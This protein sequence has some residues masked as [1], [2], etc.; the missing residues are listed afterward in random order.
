[1]QLVFIVAHKE[2][3]KDLE[4]ALVNNKHHFTK[5]DTTGGFLQKKNVTYLM[6]VEDKSV[7]DVLKIVKKTCK[8]HEEVVGQPVFTAGSPGE[9]LMPD[10]QTKIKVGGATVFTVKAEKF[11]KI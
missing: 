4:E 9:M 2:N 6:G 7:D 11:E 8:T 3:S 1:M 10:G 5:L